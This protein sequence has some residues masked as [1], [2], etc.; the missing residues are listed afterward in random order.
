MK[1]KANKV[2][3]VTLCMVFCHSV[4]TVTALLGGGDTETLMAYFHCRTPIQIRTWTRIPVLCKIFP[5][6]WT[7]ILSL[8]CM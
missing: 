5:L 3:P 8:K 6:V 7:L 4:S 1:G 2:A